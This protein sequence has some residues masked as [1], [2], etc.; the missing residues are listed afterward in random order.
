[1][2]PASIEVCIGLSISEEFTFFLCVGAHASARERA[3]VFTCVGVTA[4]TSHIADGSP[5]MM[6]T[7]L[8][9]VNT[10]CRG[11]DPSLHTATQLITTNGLLLFA[12]SKQLLC[13]LPPG[14][15]L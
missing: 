12:R 2:P 1:M 8:L 7:W 11:M 10:R 4:L 9:K 15:R 5:P 6:D 3:H 13:N 14:Y